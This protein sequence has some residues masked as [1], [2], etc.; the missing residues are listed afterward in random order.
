ML[1]KS[2]PGFPLTLKDGY[3]EASFVQEMTIVVDGKALA[4]PWSAYAGLFNVRGAEL[5]LETGIFKLVTGGG[6]GADTYSV[7]IYFN[8][9]RVIKLESYDSFSPDK[10]TAVFLYAPPLVIE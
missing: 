9:K 6:G 8:S 3:N 2:D 7:R 1:K 4:V 10:P 5:T